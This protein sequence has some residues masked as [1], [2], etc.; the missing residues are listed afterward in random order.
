M[1]PIEETILSLLAAA[2]PGKSIDPMAVARI[3]QPER[4]QRAL[5][6]VRST[7]IGMA[8]EGRIV[9][10]RHGKPASPDDFKGV[11]RM[12]LPGPEEAAEDSP[13]A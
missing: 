7:A 11:W 6:Q 3:I 4:W 1:S 2:E 9:I 5:G 10:L 8:R 12:R 13:E